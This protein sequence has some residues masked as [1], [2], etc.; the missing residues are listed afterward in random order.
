MSTNFRLVSILEKYKS[1][2]GEDSAEQDFVYKH[3][4]NIEVFDGPGVAEIKAAIAAAPG[5]AI[6]SDPRHGYKPDE[7]ASVYE[8]LDIFELEQIKEALAESNLDEETI[9]QIEAS[10]LESSSS[11]MLKIIDEAVSDFYQEATDEEKS[12]L[13]EMLS[14]DEGYA[15]LLDMIFEEDDTE[16]DEDESEEM[17]DEDESE[18]DTVLKSPIKK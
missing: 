9:Q 6:H 8:N 3:T 1:R 18:E 7:D 17:D 10:L 13:D 12:V 5:H 4:D 14:T 11:Q 2:A 15:E 16:E